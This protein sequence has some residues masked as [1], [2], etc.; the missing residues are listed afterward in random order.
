MRA[1]MFILR[2]KMTTGHGYYRDAH[3]AYRQR[4]ADF[5]G[6]GRELPE[7]LKLPWEQ[8]AEEY[9]DLLALVAAHAVNRYDDDG[10]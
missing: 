3:Q 2:S 8:L 4:R 1:A 9:K 6:D 7:C 10:A 5:L